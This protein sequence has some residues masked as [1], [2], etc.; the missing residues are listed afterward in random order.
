MEKITAIKN[1]AEAERKFNSSSFKQTRLLL[2]ELKNYLL[3]C[4]IRATKRM[5]VVNSSI[6]NQGLNQTTAL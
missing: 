6:C 4:G 1:R 3:I 5:E 2:N